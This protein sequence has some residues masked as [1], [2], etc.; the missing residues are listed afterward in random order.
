MRAPKWDVHTGSV[1]GFVAR[2]STWFRLSLVTRRGAKCRSFYAGKSR[3]SWKAPPLLRTFSP[4]TV[5]SAPGGSRDKHDTKTTGRAKPF[6]R[7]NLRQSI[8]R[9]PPAGSTD[10][11]ECRDQR[12]S[13]A[14]FPRVP[15]ANRAVIDP[16]T[17]QAF[18]LHPVAPLPRRR[19]QPKAT[20]RFL[21]RPC[22]PGAIDEERGPCLRVT[23][24]SIPPRPRSV[25]ARTVL[26]P[27]SRPVPAPAPA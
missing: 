17:S 4:Q 13:G 10:P 19:I 5:T 14:A 18:M 15:F 23:L 8:D 27:P 24:A 26:I 1:F 6:F 22:S 21:P 12:P 7:L 9:L 11:A 20:C 16:S 25:R 3:Q 2:K